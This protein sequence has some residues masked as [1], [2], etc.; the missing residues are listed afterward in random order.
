MD[1]ANGLDPDNTDIKSQLSQVLYILPFDLRRFDIKVLLYIR[2]GET[3][4]SNDFATLLK[5]GL[6]SKD[7]IC[8][9]LK[10]T[11]FKPCPADP[12]YALPL[13]TM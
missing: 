3:T 13:Q 12:G 1:H 9:F 5:R 4:L 10:W 6:L 11:R 7:V 2:S 8:F